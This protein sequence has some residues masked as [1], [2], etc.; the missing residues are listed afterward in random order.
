MRL[1]QISITN[2]RGI[3]NFHWDLP[4]RQL[5]CLIGQGDSG[6][7]TI[8]E[9]IRRLFHPQWNLSF[10]DAD[11]FQGNPENS[12]EIVGVL[13]AIPAELIQLHVRYGTR[14]SGWNA[15]TLKWAEEPGDGLEDVLRA[16]L[17]VG[18]DLEP[19][20]TVIQGNKED[21]LRFWPTDREKVSAHLVGEHA[22]RHLRWARGSMLSQIT[23]SENIAA[24]LAVANRA[25]KEAVEGR[26][27]ENLKGFDDAAATAEQTARELGVVVTDKYK[28]HLDSDAFNM[29]SSGL[30]LHDGNVPL[31]RLG[32]GSKRMLATGLQRK[33]QRAPHITLFDEVEA[34]LEPHRIA[35]LLK[36]LKEDRCGQYFVTTHSPVVLR[37]LIIDDIHVLHNRAGNAEVVATSQPG[38][39]DLLQ[40]KIRSGAEA[41]LAPKIIVCEG[42]TEVGFL[43]GLDD[44]WVDNE[45]RL[46]FAYRGVALFDAG[47][48]R[49][50]DGASRGLKAL[51]YDVAV[52]VDSDAP[53]E[54]SEKDA[55]NLRALGV[56][57]GM[58]SDGVSIE[59]R[60]FAD[61]PWVGVSASIDAYREMKG[62]DAVVLDQIQSKF[63]ADFDRDQQNWHDNPKLRAAIGNAAKS[64]EWFKR[65][66]RARIW[67]QI[68]ARH[69]RDRAIGR[70][71]LVRVTSGLQQWVENG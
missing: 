47:G 21:G 20:W 46:S 53:D 37:E 57:V 24:S 50:V 29:R 49:R 60:V 58:W 5:F 55:A 39:T 23:D 62:D 16:R 56:T 54:F 27:E 36:H 69:L 19:S 11:F 35:R 61:L 31:R 12:I 28:A 64:S 71:D 17:A 48:G 8:L 67:G 34:G 30:A 18:D 6:K 63:G 10:D 41:F 2:F 65:Q 33:A 3:S 59:Q 9:A 38:L 68:V 13:G 66:D 52:L 14:I 4:D 45:D 43:R 70:S 40:G 42:T 32:L 51:K 1:R 7:S 15:Q 25:A 22:D 26:R 44:Y